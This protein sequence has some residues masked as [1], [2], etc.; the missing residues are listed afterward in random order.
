MTTQIKYSFSNFIVN[1]LGADYLRIMR[2]VNYC[3]KNNI[4]F[5]LSEKDNWEIAPYTKNWREIFKSLETSD[6]I[7][8]KIVDDNF[9]SKALNEIL[10][11]DDFSNLCRKHFIIQDKYLNKTPVLLPDRYAVIHV[12]RGDKVTTSWREGIK[13]EFN[14]YY[15]KIKDDFKNSEIFVMTDSSDVIDEIK[16]RG[17]LYDENEIRRDGFVFKHYN[18]NYN[19]NEL[20]DEL[21]TFV[22]N[23]NIFKNA[24]TLVGS[25]ASFF[26]ILGQLL[27]KKRG[28]SLSE[29]KFYKTIFK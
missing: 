17:F 5:Y 24:S 11:F 9:L 18:N 27:N 16:T 22:N 4:K 15:D 29:N 8:I 14:E 20:E 7:N 23:M 10:D 21:K 26:Y 2:L 25:N 1:G 28:I 13:H 6:D 12:R 3:N 19:D